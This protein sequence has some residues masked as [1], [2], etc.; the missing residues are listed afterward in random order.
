MLP[1]NA[2]HRIPTAFRTAP[3]LSNKETDGKK[4]YSKN[5]F[6]GQVIQKGQASINFDGFKPLLAAIVGVQKDYAGR[7]AAKKAAVPGGP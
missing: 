1:E 2:P 3:D 7:V 6:A 4:F 5:E